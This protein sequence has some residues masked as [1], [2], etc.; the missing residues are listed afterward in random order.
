[1]DGPV[2]VR[3]LRIIMAGLVVAPIAA[4][5][6]GSESGSRSESLSCTNAA[7][8]SSGTP[9]RIRVAY[10]VAAEE[11]LWLMDAMPELTPNQGKS[12]ELDMRRYDNTETKMVAY[13]A[14]EVDAVSVPTVAQIVGTA[15]GALDL[16]TLFT[17]MQDAGEGAF[18]TTFVVRPDSDIRT[19]EDLEGRTIGL[20]DFGSS[21]D[22]LARM[23]M[24]KAGLDFDDAKY[25]TIPW[26]AQVEALN[27]GVLDV[28]V[29]VEPFFAMSQNAESPAR[30]LFTSRDVTGY[31][32]DQLV[33]SIDRDFA[34]DHL[35][36]VCDFRDDYAKALEWYEANMGEARTALVEAGYVGV[37][38]EIYQQTRDFARPVAGAFD[39]SGLERMMDDM[40]SVGFL[41]ESDRIDPNEI[42]EPGFTA[43]L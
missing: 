35:E 12:Y 2:R 11:P 31:A 3:L 25:S 7:A 10:G 6:S 23:A 32:F 40:I 29:T 26:P 15:K 4:C 22:F 14:G 24:K 5:G 18:G 27:S 16:V 20:N 42:A 28:A 33:L 13:Q 38:L 41:D 19:L 37:P 1:M 17:E 21:P 8:D 34:A 36:A 30:T 39:A 9:A 43:G